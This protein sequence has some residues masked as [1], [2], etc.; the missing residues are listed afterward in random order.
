MEGQV[1]L[2]GDLFLPVR[3]WVAR[4]LLDL[5]RRDPLVVASSHERV[6]CSPIADVI[7]GLT[8]RSAN[9]ARRFVAAYTEA[10]VDEFVLLSTSSET[11]QLD[12]LTAAVL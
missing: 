7:A 9:E 12:E 1:R 2:A 11:E 6:R 4:H 10:V 8:V 3:L 5:V